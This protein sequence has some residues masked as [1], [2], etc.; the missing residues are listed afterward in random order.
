MPLGMIIL[1]TKST[2]YLTKTEASGKGILPLSV[3]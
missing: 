1:S 2:D 3:G